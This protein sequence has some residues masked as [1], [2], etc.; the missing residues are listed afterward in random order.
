MKEK[1]NRCIY[2][3][4]YTC[5]ILFIENNLQARLRKIYIILIITA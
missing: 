1:Y 3:V 5:N 4:Y 2:Q